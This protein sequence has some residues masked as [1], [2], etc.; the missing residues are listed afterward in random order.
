MQSQ[1]EIKIFEKKKHIFD[2]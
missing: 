2:P 1:D